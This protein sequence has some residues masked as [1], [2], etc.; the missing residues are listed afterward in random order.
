MRFDVFSPGWRSLHAIAL[1][2]SWLVSAPREAFACMTPIRCPES[3]T[4]P[5][6]RGTLPAN[7]HGLLWR[8]CADTPEGLARLDP[9][10]EVRGVNESWRPVRISFEERGLRPRETTYYVSWRDEL[11][12]GTDVVFSFDESVPA[13]TARH[14]G[15][16]SPD[17]DGGSP[18]SAPTILRR[19]VSLRIGESADL[20]EAGL[21]LHA[22]TARG[23]FPLL[24]NGGDCTH[25]LYASYVDI[26]VIPTWEAL[27]WSNAQIFETWVDDKPWK[28]YRVSYPGNPPDGWLGGSD[29]GPNR[30]RLFL[31]C[32]WHGVPA[33]LAPLPPSGLSP[34]HHTTYVVG[35]L[36]DGAQL[37]SEVYDFELECPDPSFWR[38]LDGSWKD[39][40]LGSPD[41]DASIPHGREAGV[42][43][44]ALN[45]EP[46]AASGSCALVGNAIVPRSSALSLW[47]IAAVLWGR[48]V[49]STRRRTARLR[50]RSH[51]L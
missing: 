23:G 18:A 50:R 8:V 36:P 6:D 51:G 15:I 45:D 16:G 40:L 1:L 46:A 11:E 25:I 44:S 7:M 38:E 14:L 12:P 49:Q 48:R 5:A 24:S 3:R 33:S 39:N 19:R 20:P 35:H 41:L 13:S 9:R 43:S 28:P 32:E 31:P 22:S 27:P 29:L 2:A 34:G 17:E 26:D 10:V 37:R 21:A 47:C 42:Q 4:I 30:E